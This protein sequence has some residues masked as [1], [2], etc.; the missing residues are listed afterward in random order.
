MTNDNFF[1]ITQNRIEISG[2]KGEHRFLHISDTHICHTDSLSTP[3][4]A[5]MAAKKE[6]SWQNV[7]RDFAIHFGERFGKEQ[8]ISSTR[9]FGKLIDYAAEQK[10][11][12]LIMSGDIVDFVHSAGLRFVTDSL[13]KSGLTYLYANGNHEGSFASHPELMCLNGGTDDIGVYHGDGFVIAAIDNSA[14]T[15]SDKQLMQL[16]AI[17]ECGTPI[18]LVMHIPLSLEYNRED[19][20]VFGEYFLLKDTTED[21]NAKELIEMIVAHDSPVKAILCGHV[22]GYHKGDFA[23]GR[24]QICS[25]SSLIGAIDDVVICGKIKTTK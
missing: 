22:H 16:K 18:I 21:K 15:V 3:Q 20:K 5:D 11:K 8:E 19:M 13:K 4:E 9:A 12:A 17:F 23:P 10:P 25:S 14:K 24:P 7:K 1:Q 2:V 6:A